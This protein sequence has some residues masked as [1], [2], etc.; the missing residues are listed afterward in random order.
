MPRP[1]RC[2]TCG[3]VMGSLWP[4]YLS[5]LRQGIPER[6]ALDEVGVPT[7]AYCC[8]AMALTAGGDPVFCREDPEGRA[9]TFRSQQLSKLELPPEAPEDLVF[10]GALPHT[11]GQPGDG[12]SDRPAGYIRCR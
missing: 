6:Q 7:E 3:R 4:Q 8:R 11:D 2:F 10:P 1:L 9:Y 12:D 5:R